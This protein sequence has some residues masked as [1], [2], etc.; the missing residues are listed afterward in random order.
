MVAARPLIEY[1]GDVS[2]RDAELL[3]KLAEGSHRILEFGVGASTQI[4][5]AYGRGTVDA[6]DTSPDWIAKTKRNLARLGIGESTV[7]FHDYYEFTPAGMYDLIF[8]DGMNE[9]RLP[10]A[11]MMWR[12]LITGGRMALHDT[13]R[14]HPYGKAD[15]SDVQHVAAILERHST[16]ILR[17]DLNQNDSNTTVIVKREPLLLEDYNAIEGRTP[18][19]LGLA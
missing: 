12:S 15:T 9:L 13:R 6:V 16:E 7:R 5:A 11:L 3:K 18:E 14:T 17:V 1:I 2:R 10:F 19:Q 4:F 8:V